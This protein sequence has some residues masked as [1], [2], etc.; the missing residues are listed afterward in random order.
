M[1]PGKGAEATPDISAIALLRSSGCVDEAY[2]RQQVSLPAGADAVEHYATSGWQQGI[3]PNPRF[4]AVF[5]GPFYEAA[6]LTGPP[7]LR[8]LE[9]CS[10]GR[11]LPSNLKEAERPAKA[12]EDCPLFDAS[13]YR[14]LLPDGMDP[15]LH[16]VVVGEG[17]GWRPS[18]HF[19]P[20][21]YLDRYPDIAAAGVSPLLHFVASGREEGR[22]PLPLAGSL[23]VPPLTGDGAPIVLVLS[24]EL[25]RT[26][27]P[28]LGWNLIRS[29]A[30]RYRVVSISMRMG[31][32]KPDFETVAA[33]SVGPMIGEY[34]DPIEARRIAAKI[35][36]AYRPIYA[37]VNSIEAR[38]LA[39]SL[40]EAGVPAI[41]LVHEFAAYTRPLHGMR[42]IFDFASDVVF[43]ARMLQNLR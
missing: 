12:V 23:I 17:L 5:L 22:R 2:Y 16:Y 1:M 8:W 7:A 32:L 27:A 30:S 6:G 37:I 19:D 43:P 15:F 10:M 33:A 35:A 42:E 21:Y 38:A 31:E 4:D 29:L 26:G 39:P 24:H 13:A 28:V 14:R 36:E 9:L 11:A 34:W 41:A 18:A 40:V 3:S 25:S 20:T